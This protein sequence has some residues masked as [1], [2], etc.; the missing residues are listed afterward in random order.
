MLRLMLRLM[1]GLMLGLEHNPAPQP[2]PA[3][4]HNLATGAAAGKAMCSSCW[5]SI[6]V[7]REK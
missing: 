5:S 1:L 3:T 6:M 7:W 2:S 4:Y